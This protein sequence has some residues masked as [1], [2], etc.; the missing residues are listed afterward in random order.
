VINGKC[1]TNLKHTAQ[2]ALLF[3]LIHSS[4]N[5]LA[6]NELPE[7]KILKWNTDLWGENPADFGRK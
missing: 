6:E 4:E 3:A 5:W 1:K 7:N 2:N